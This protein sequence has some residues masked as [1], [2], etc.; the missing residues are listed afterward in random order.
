MALEEGTTAA[1]NWMLFNIGHGWK[2][3]YDAKYQSAHKRKVTGIPPF[4]SVPPEIK[5]SSD[6]FREFSAGAAAGGFP[7]CEGSTG[8]E[9]DD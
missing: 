6:A 3:A 2:H 5:R 4:K 8:E 9:S 7:E 1:N